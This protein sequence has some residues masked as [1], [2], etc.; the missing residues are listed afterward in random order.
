[1]KRQKQ[2][3]RQRTAEEKRQAESRKRSAGASTGRRKSV[4]RST[5][6]RMKK[7][8]GWLHDGLYPNCT[9]IARDLEVSV[10]HTWGLQRLEGSAKKVRSIR[11]LPEPLGQ[12]LSRCPGYD[13]DQKL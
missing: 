5:F 6:V 2:T 3:S 13:F 4:T 1:M 8:F 11:I 7:I 10:T 9:R 12:S